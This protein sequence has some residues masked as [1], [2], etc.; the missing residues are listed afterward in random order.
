[1]KLVSIII[2]VYNNKSTIR[3]CIESSINQT[4]EDIEIILINDGSQDNSLK[5]LEE[6]ASKYKKKIKLYNKENTGIADTRNF[7]VEKAEGKYIMFLDADDYISVELLQKLKK[8]ME[9]GIELI[10]YKMKI[11]EGAKEKKTNSISFEDTSGEEGFNKL[12]FTDVFMDSPCLYLIDKTIFTKNNLKFTKNTYHEDFGLMPFVIL[13]AK[14]MVSTDIYGYNYIQS[15]NSIMRN[16][17]YEKT[18]KKANDMLIHYDNMIEKVKNTKIN[19]KTIEN[20]KIYYTN[21]IILKLYELKEKE[22]NQYI[23]EIR[24]R[25]MQNNIKARNIKQ[26]IKK[27]ILNLNI[28]LYLKIR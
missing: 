25:K 8:Y 26:F 4:M 27:I 22:Q 17:D 15:S 7:G 16:N 9:Q 21:S 1:M 23:K 24:K 18:I 14:T 20:L 2:P 19:P 10:K 28:K 12:C 6:Y 13:N 11:I 5:V 3:R